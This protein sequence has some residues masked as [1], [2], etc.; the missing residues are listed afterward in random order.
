MSF[1]IRLDC[2]FLG[3]LF[4]LPLLLAVLSAEVLLYPREVAECPGRVVVD[5]ALLWTDVHLLLD[6]LVGPLTQ[7]PWKVVA[8]SVKLK[9]LIPLEPFVAYLADETV[10]GHESLWR[11][12]NDLGIWICNTNS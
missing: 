10:G 8:P 11:K 3:A 12:S 2:V 9:V 1:P 4:A 5:A 7:L 6:L